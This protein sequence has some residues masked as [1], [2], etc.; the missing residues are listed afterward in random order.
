MS[1]DYVLN[2]QGSVHQTDAAM[3]GIRPSQVS[4]FSEPEPKFNGYRSKISETIGPD[5]HTSQNQSKHRQSTSLKIWHCPPLTFTMSS[6]SS[7]TLQKADE[8]HERLGHSRDRWRCWR[9]CRHVCDIVSGTTT[10]PC[11]AERESDSCSWTRNIVD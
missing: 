8:H 3:V 9:H 6:S 5:K 10:R 4:E 2:W 1:T 11:S 7:P